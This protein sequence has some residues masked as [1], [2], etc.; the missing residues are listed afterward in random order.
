MADTTCRMT[1]NETET[2]K[3]KTYTM[4]TCI[5]RLRINV[6]NYQQRWL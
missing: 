3:R 4:Q 2:T 5:N 6:L 1:D